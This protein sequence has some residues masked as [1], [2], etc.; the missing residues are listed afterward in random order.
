MRNFSKNF[1]KL[2]FK[3]KISEKYVIHKIILCD[4]E[5]TKGASSYIFL[6]LPFDEKYI[7]AI[8]KRKKAKRYIWL[9]IAVVL[10]VKHISVYLSIS[11]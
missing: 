3:I 5:Q 10:N 11:W 9:F 2:T 8:Q 4:I 7:G 1:K 6:A